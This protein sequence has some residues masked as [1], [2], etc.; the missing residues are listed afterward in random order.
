M[1]IFIYDGGDIIKKDKVSYKDKKDCD[2]GYLEIIDISKH[3]KPLY[4][5]PC[6][7]D[8]WDAIE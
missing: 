8:T 5:N 6:C 1:Y 3:L 2:M 7:S 4:Y